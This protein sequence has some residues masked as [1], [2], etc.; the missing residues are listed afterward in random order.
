MIHDQALL[1]V[2]PAAAKLDSIVKL[3]GK[4]PGMAEQDAAELA[5][6][7]RRWA[8]AGGT[9]ARKLLRRIHSLMRRRCF[10]CSK[11]R[12]RPRLP[13]GKGMRSQRSSLTN[14]AEARE[15]GSDVQR[16]VPDANIVFV[17]GVD[18]DGIT[19]HLPNLKPVTVLAARLPE[20]HRY[21]LRR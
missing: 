11:R 13:P 10:A 21:L 6:V 9:C 1:I 14:S 19:T 2:A 7:R 5:F 20:G 12:Y 15:F 17:G 4:R 16:A 3:G 8:I 18:G